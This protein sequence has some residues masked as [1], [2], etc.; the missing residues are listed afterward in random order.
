MAQAA[1]KYSL[2]QVPEKKLLSTAANT[3]DACTDDS[4]HANSLRE[5][6]GPQNRRKSPAADAA[7]AAA[8]AATAQR[9]VR[10][11]AKEHSDRY[12]SEGRKEGSYHRIYVT[13]RLTLFFI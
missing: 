4:L 12:G 11:G 7:V 13:Y 10:L 9:E 6:A 8:V 1:F 3:A 2:D 5:T